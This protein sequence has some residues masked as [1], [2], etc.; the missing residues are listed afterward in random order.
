MKP[1]QIATLSTLFILTCVLSL[2]A[3]A[4]ART[5]IP[6]T[7]SFNSSIY[8]AGTICS[9]CK[10]ELSPGVT[11]TINSTCSCNNCTF[12]GGAGVI[13][14]PSSFTLSGVDSFENETVTLNNSF[15]IPSNGVTFY[16]D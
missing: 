3:G 15:S 5:V 9:N 2:S 16:G 1:T 12:V 13:V 7:S 4:Q 11:I 14:S 6:I 8:G 10:L